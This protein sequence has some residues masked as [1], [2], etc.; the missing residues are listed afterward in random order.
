MAFYQTEQHEEQG[1]DTCE[2][3]QDAQAG[4]GVP[5]GHEQAE[6]ERAEDLPQAHGHVVEA[7]GARATESFRRWK[8]ERIGS[9]PIGG[10]GGVYG[11]KRN[12]Q[13]G[14]GNAV[15]EDQRQHTQ[16]RDDLGRKERLHHVSRLVDKS[17]EVR[18]SEHDDDAVH[19]ENAADSGRRCAGLA[20]RER[21]EELEQAH[22]D[23]RVGDDEE[24][25]KCAHAAIAEKGCRFTQT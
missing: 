19:E 20:Q 10:D 1:T 16:C 17:A 24:E 5:C 4:L 22:R 13:H 3:G 7:H 9:L 15:E 25:Q 6:A 11:E 18:P 8:G 14:A 23:E 12:A 2:G 21:H